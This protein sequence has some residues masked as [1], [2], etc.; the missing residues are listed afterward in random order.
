MCPFAAPTVDRRVCGRPFGRPHERARKVP[1]P[2]IGRNTILHP[3]K[4]AIQIDSIGF[5]MNHLVCNIGIVPRAGQ[6][7]FGAGGGRAARGSGAPSA[8]RLVQA[9]RRRGMTAQLPC[10]ASLW[11]CL[12]TRVASRRLRPA[13][14]RSLESTPSRTSHDHDHPLCAPTRNRDRWPPPAP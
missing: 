8:P 9:S 1:P 11:R 6:P 4:Y 10:A 13:P 2:L 7:A 3:Y 14:N 12:G 5:D